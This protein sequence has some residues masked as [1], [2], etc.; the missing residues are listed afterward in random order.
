MYYYLYDNYSKEQI[1]YFTL[2]ILLIADLPIIFFTFL[3]IFK[4]KFLNKYRINYYS[5]RK[6]PNKNE[7]IDGTKH[8]FI[9]FFGI[10]LPI[11][12]FGIFISNY[13]SYFPYNM[14][15]E[16]PNNIIILSHIMFIFIL[17]DILFYG[18]HN[19]IHTPNLYKMFHKIHHKYNEPFSLTNHYIHPLELILFFIPPVLPGIILNTHITIMWFTTIILNWNGIFI[20]SGYDFSKNKYLDYI[21]PSA[22]E[23]DLHHRLYNCNFGS[24]FT[25]MD[26][27]FGTYKKFYPNI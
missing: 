22:K 12:T 7:I 26:K 24:T 3:D 21:M 27:L 2:F 18:L 9:N 5:Y 19:L 14:N 1:M 10:I 23:H 16:L 8:S 6:Y 20:H 13:I 11:S 25:F 15:R 4:L 17:S